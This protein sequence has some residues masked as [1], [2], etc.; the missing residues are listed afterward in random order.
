MDNIKILDCTLRDGGYVNSWN[1]GEN[2]I[3]QTLHNLQISKIDYVECGF[4]KDCEYNTDKTLFNRI[5][6]INKFF[7]SA[8]TKPDMVV[9]MIMFGQFSPGKLVPKSPDIALDAI[10]V[11]FKKHEI[12]KAFK[13]LKKI[14]EFGYKVFVNP[15][16]IDSYSDL[17]IIELLKKVNELNPYAFSIVDT[18][19]ILKENDILRLY[20][21]INTNL[22]QNIQLGFHSHNNLQLSFS[23]AQILMKVC[24]KRELII[25]STVF[26]MGRGAGNLCTE[27]LTQY[28]NDNYNGTYN[29]IPILKIV[30][31]F[32]N[33]IFTQTPWGYSV[34][35]YL[36]ATNHCHPNYARYLVD[37]QT[38][39]VEI[40]NDILA[41]LPNEKRTTYDENFIRQVYLDKFH[42][43][44]NDSNTLK[45]I[46]DEIK[47]KTILILAPGKSISSQKA[48]IDAFIKER[49][50]FIFALNFLPENYKID[51]VF[52]TNIKR[53]LSL[54][55]TSIPVIISSNISA[56]GDNI[57]IIN[58]SAYLNDS[59]M[60]DNVALMLLK[61]LIKI[62]VKRVYFAGMDGFSNIPV[63][64][65]FAENLVS[66]AKVSENENYNAIMKELFSKFRKNIEIN[67]ITKSLYGE[68]E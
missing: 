30:D 41:T 58:Y 36:A 18:K 31:E 43:K 44:I 8:N 60:F 3:S 32:I 39:P 38:V 35:Y 64:N 68:N 10:R 12:D 42:S 17:E 28:I 54:E 5:E 26:G 2:G 20:Y 23:N 33:P 13:F 63:E 52:I 11:T 40:I 57:K 50:P 61:L 59:K 56:C 19:G 15:T 14:Q 62:G 48:E 47:D 46:Q 29:I 65:Y 51:M 67:F 45:Y 21:L 4:L 24:S 49:N 6:E 16:N 25:D 9:A 22:K 37:K 7:P 27:L 34:P 53:F 55:K 66:L 1:F